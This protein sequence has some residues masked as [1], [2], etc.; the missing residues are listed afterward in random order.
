MALHCKLQG[1][2]SDKRG[3]ALQW[4][5]P[6]LEQQVEACSQIFNSFGAWGALDLEV[7]VRG[8]TIAAQLTVRP[9]FRGNVLLRAIMACLPPK[10]RKANFRR[11][12]HPHDLQKRSQ[13]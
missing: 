9:W 11:S 3:C 6:R 5:L 4:Q 13:Y 2:S 12:Y 10:R 7:F 8:I 1:T